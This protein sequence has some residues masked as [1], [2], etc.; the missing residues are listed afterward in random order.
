VVDS[1]TTQ[2]IVNNPEILKNK[3]LKNSIINFLN[4][5]SNKSN[6]S[7][8]LKIKI[9]PEIINAMISNRNRLQITKYYT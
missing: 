8:K 6:I 2:T 5:K 7:G 4:S 1:G 3:E 9:G